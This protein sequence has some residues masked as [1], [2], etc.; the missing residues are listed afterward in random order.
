MKLTSMLME[1]NWST[2]LEDQW[3]ETSKLSL[4]L[5]LLTTVLLLIL[6]RKDGQSLREERT[7]FHPMEHSCSWR[8]C[9][10]WLTIFHLIWFQFMM[11]WLFHLSTMNSESAFIKRQVMNWMPKMQ[12]CKN[13]S[14]QNT[15]QEELLQCHHQWFLQ[16][17]L[18][19]RY[20][21]IQLKFHQMLM[22]NLPNLNNLKKASH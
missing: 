5:F 22:K 16:K 17:N 14:Q 12:Q 2:P 20:Q 6:M 9:N 3:R 7:S 19:K 4:R 1:A 21:L 10:K 18:L 13:S 15:L 11:T 8:A